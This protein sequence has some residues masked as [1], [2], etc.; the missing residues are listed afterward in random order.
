MRK[1]RRSLSRLFV[2]L[3]AVIGILSVAIPAG[4]AI[5]AATVVPTPNTSPTDTN[6]LMSVSCVSSVSC[7]AVGTSISSGIL[8]PLIESW[9][10]ATWSLQI[11]PS[12]SPTENN[13]LNGVA[14]T[15]PSSCVAVGAKYSGGNWHALAMSW[16]GTSWA[17]Q[18]SANSSPTEDNTLMSVSCAAADSC[19]AVGFYLGTNGY[20]TIAE[21]WDGSTWS[22]QLSANAPPPSENFLNGVTCLSVN[23]CVAVG[24]HSANNIS[25]TLV[26]VWNGTVWA[27]QSSANV[28]ASNQNTLNSV[29]CVSAS[30]C[31][32]VG[33]YLDGGHNRSLFEIWDGSAW[34]VQTSPVVSVQ[35]D[36]TVAVSCVS[37]STC[38][39]VG[40]LSDGG[41][42]NTLV[43]V[44]DGS[45]WSVQT[46]PNGPGG[47]NNFLNGVSCTS[48]YSCVAVGSANDGT[49]DRTL[50]LSLTGPAPPVPTTV[51]SSSTT[52]GPDPVAPSFTG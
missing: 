43:S 30:S 18:A 33:V 38:V 51:P 8:Q 50:V 16:D 17:I 31:F 6:R 15:S 11:A 44:W 27:V 49:A 20:Q 40:T 12:S 7:V 37:P 19:V 47:G 26:E 21:A 35:F 5:D 1:S 2:A 45:T 13:K 24:Y 46:S 36:Y 9:D 42:R 3:A 41:V 52:S 10:G 14:C 25:E 48:S 34:S 23:S 29:S 22:M 32:A 39:A 4:A 28:P